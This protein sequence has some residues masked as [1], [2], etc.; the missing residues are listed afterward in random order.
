[1]EPPPLPWSSNIALGFSIRKLLMI[2]KMRLSW[3][4]ETYI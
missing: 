2:F 4:Q 1:M 3:V